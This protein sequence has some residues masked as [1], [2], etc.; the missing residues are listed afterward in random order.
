MLLPVTEFQET[1]HPSK[2]VLVFLHGVFGRAKNF[3]QIAR[4][5]SPKIQCIALD[6]RNHGEASSGPL[7]L[8]AM[9]KD[10]IQTCQELHLENIILLGH[11]MGGKIAM[12]AAL[13]TPDN[14]EWQHALKSVIIADIAPVP[15]PS[16]YGNMAANLAR[17][18]FPSL[19]TRRAAADFLLEQV[20]EVTEPAIAAWLAQNLVPGKYPFWQTNMAQ[21]ALDFNEIFRW[22][23]KDTKLTPFSSP[24]LFIKGG[25]S[26]HIPQH[27][28]DEIFRLFPE[29]ELKILPNAGHWVHAEQPETFIRFITKFLSD[30]SFIS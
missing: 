29:T 28:E 6:L 26:D 11:S 23:S 25:K 13:E 9:A 22:P 3:G 12:A 18:E 17:L 20:A 16:P 8:S 30:H 24:A 4:A 21:I 19:P 7:N 5:L 1:R 27:S 10:V 15:A 14:A 2:P